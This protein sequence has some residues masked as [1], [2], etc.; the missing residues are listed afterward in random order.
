MLNFT[1]IEQYNSDARLR[2]ARALHAENMKRFKQGPD[3][4]H[5]KRI[6]SEN[7]K[8]RFR[9]YNPTDYYSHAI[10]LH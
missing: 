9:D 2:E 1:E 4:P 8:L 7:A 3:I 5:L 6:A 10:R